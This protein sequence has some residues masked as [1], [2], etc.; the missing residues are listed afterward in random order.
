MPSTIT[1]H[2]HGIFGPS[3]RIRKNPGRLSLPLSRGSTSSSMFLV[4]LKREMECRLSFLTSGPSTDPL[5]SLTLLRGAGGGGPP[6]RLLLPPP[7]GFVLFGCCWNTKKTSL[8]RTFEAALPDARQN[9][10]ENCQMRCCHIWVFLSFK[11]QGGVAGSISKR[12][13]TKYF[14]DV[15]SKGL[16][17][18]RMCSMWQHRIQRSLKT[19]IPD[20]NVEKVRPAP[21]QA[22]RMTSHQSLINKF[23]PHEL[24][25][26]HLYVNST[27]DLETFPHC[28]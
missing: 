13:F 17:T 10:T 25:S 14:Q 8:K 16:W 28:C 3:N 27:V 12:I 2:S 9:S 20:V 18:T 19:Y 26:G 6:A 11:R 5:V 4:M 24:L 15:V 1:G 22:L 7:G 21:S 23:L